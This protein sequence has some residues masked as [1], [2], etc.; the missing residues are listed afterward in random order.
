MPPIINLV[1]GI[2]LCIF[3]GFVVTFGVF[4]WGFHLANP[5]KFRPPIFRELRNSEEN[6]TDTRQTIFNSK[7][8]ARNV[9]SPIRPRICVNPGWDG[10]TSTKF[11]NVSGGNES[12]D[13]L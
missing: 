1:G 10:A 8:K 13:S 7:R 11:R 4:S 9:S 12:T 5:A 3:S 6:L 2:F